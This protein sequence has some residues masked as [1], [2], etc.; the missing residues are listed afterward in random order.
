MTDLDHIPSELI[1]GLDVTS[2]S[3]LSGGDVADA[4]RLETAD[5]ALFAKTHPHPSPGLFERE[6]TGLQALREH[7]PAGL[8]V[9]E[10]VRESAG[11]LVLEWID[12][13]GHRTAQTE[14]DLGVGLA[15]LHRTA[16]ATFGGLDGARH[17]YLGSARVDLTPE[18]DWVA[19]YTDRRVAPLLD[20]AVAAGRLDP[21]A[22]G[23][24]ERVRPHAAELCG[25]TEPPALLHGDLW[26]G[27]RVVDAGGSNWLIDPAVHWGHREYDLAMMELFGGFGDA[28]FSAYDE[29]F[30]LGDGRRERVPWYQLT[31]LLVHALLFGGHYGPAAMRVLERYA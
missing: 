25:P 3:P 9:P 14:R 27:N 23:L 30:P 11:G 16:N 6:S 4:W 15:G 22:Q 19:F 24:F 8:C 2:A 1:D 31:P 20:Q 17:G 5:G 13:S 28:C 18:D 21:A 7:A 10:V 26:A 12:T 29:A